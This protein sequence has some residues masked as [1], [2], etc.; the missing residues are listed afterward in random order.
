[1]GMCDEIHVKT[2]EDASWLYDYLC[3]KFDMYV[4][5]E[6]R[7]REKDVLI[8]SLKYFRNL[9]YLTKSD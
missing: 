7:Q 1:M 8:A 4:L 5:M 2:Y 3:H 6:T 9:Y